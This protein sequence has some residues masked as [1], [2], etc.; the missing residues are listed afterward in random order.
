MFAAG[1]VGGG[2]EGGPRGLVVATHISES[3]CGGTRTRR[4]CNSRE[5]LPQGLKANSLA[6]IHAK[7]KALA[8]LEAKATKVFAYL[9]DWTT[10][11]DLLRRLDH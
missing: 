7:A 4:A 6:V 11:S 1:G 10:K 9:E 8:Y 5:E 3:R 2:V